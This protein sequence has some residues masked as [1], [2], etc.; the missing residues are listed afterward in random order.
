[1]A[2]PS[3]RSETK[4]PRT[5]KNDCDDNSF[6][7]CFIFSVIYTISDHTRHDYFSKIDLAYMLACWAEFKPNCAAERKKFLE[8][9]K[10]EVNSGV[11]VLAE[12]D[13]TVSILT[14]AFLIS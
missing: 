4:L 7:F 2:S 8:A 9:V 11:C 1:M 3:S 12:G 10:E 6:W 5:P 13:K 14:Y